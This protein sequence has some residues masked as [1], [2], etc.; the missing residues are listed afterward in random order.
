MF[1]RSAIE[2]LMS[3]AINELREVRAFMCPRTKEKWSAGD[4][5]AYLSS[6]R[7]ASGGCGGVATA[8]VV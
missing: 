2:H 4:R 3:H 8:V 1:G 5:L 7:A 6:S